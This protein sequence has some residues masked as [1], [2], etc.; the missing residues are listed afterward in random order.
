MP[1][2]TKIKKSTPPSHGKTSIQVVGQT[3]PSMEIG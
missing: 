1:L 2:K 3:F